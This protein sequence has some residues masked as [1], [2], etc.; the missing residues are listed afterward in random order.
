MGEAE[1]DK[2]VFDGGAVSDRVR[3]V[4]ET[5]LDNPV[6]AAR[7]AELAV[8]RG[9]DGFEAK[10]ATGFALV[11]GKHV[12]T[13]GV[14]SREGYRRIVPDSG[15]EVGWLEWRTETLAMVAKEVLRGRSAT[16]FEARVLNPLMGLPKR[17]AEDLARQ[18][19]CTLARIYKIVDDAK[20]KLMAA[21][22]RYEQDKS[23]T[24]AA[25]KCPT[26]GRIYDNDYTWGACHY[27]YNS[28]AKLSPFTRT[29]CVP[30]AYRSWREINR[31]RFEAKK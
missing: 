19:G 8:S 13:D 6:R 25:E 26:C 17:S 14:V 4:P 31:S 9:I 1:L 12:A 20:E 2:A 3:A 24:A 11:G 7:S 22:A 23:L 21:V 15:L 27:G 16:V 5:H 30:P 18:F 29:E 10:S 28:S